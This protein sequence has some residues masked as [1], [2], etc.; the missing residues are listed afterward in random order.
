MIATDS[1]PEVRKAVSNP[2]L[3]GRRM[4]Q[5]RWLIRSLPLFWR[6]Q[7]SSLPLP[8]PPTSLSKTSSMCR[9]VCPKMPMFKRQKVPSTQ[10]STSALGILTSLGNGSTVLQGKTPDSPLISKMIRP[11]GASVHR[12][13]RQRLTSQI[14]GCTTLSVPPGVLGA[15]IGATEAFIGEA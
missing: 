12:G 2:M 4:Q 10:R 8:L 6:T 9:S 13:I 1:V 15:P 5:Q 7:R 14:E 3:Q 11:I